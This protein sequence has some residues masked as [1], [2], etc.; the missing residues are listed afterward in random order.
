MLSE[1]GENEG[2]EC[3]NFDFILALAVWDGQLISG[4]KSARVRVW[5]VS[6]GERRRELAGNTAEVGSLCVVGS[7]LAS[8]SGDGSIKVW[9]MGQ[10][11]DWPCERTLM[12]HTSVV[13]SLAEWEGKLISGSWD[14][15]V[16][17]WELETGSLDATLTGH[18]GRV[19]GLLVHRERLFSASGDGS[20]RA[21]TVGT[22]AAV[23]RVEAYDVEASGQYPRCLAASGSVGY[24]SGLEYEVRVWDVD[25][26]TCEHTMRQPAGT[27]VWCLAAAGGEV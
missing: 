9:A 2:Y 10:G 26:L 20:I 13:A 18:D 24:L 22:W 23:A 12:G 25:P 7:R 1:W 3:D 4:Q 19:Y 8:G 15:T 21:W 16:R 17:V 11:P 6:T 27:N 5:D 14:C